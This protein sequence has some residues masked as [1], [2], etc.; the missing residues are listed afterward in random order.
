MKKILLRVVGDTH[1]DLD[2]DL[3]LLLRLRDLDLDFEVFL[4]LRLRD[5]CAEK[6]A[7]CEMYITYNATF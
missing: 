6:C 5:L 1:L 4:P 2:L 3:D 7:H